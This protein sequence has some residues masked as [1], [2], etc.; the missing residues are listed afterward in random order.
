MGFDNVQEKISLIQNT[1]K[2]FVMHENSISIG[3][4]VI[5]STN[6][7]LNIRKSEMSVNKLSIATIKKCPQ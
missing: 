6:N 4:V 2:D 5:K 1:K 7:S 3:E